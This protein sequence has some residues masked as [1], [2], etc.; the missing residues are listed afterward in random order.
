MVWL[1]LTM[2]LIGGKSYGWKPNVAW[3]SQILNGEQLVMWLTLAAEAE[4]IISHD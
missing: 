2:V 1:F 3:A 4:S